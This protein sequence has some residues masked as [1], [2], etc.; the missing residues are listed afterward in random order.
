MQAVDGD[1][2]VAG[3]LD[4]LTAMVIVIGALGVYFTAAAVLVDI[5][6]DQGA[7]TAHAGL[8]AQERLADDVLKYD[9]GNETLAP[10][11]VRSFF[12][13]DANRTCGVADHGDGQAFLRGALGVGERFAVNATLEDDRGP[14]TMDPTGGGRPYRH[15]IGASVPDDR[16]VTV[17]ERTVTFGDDTDGDGRLDYFT[18]RLRLWEGSP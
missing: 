1:R 8:R 18:V 14:V 5:Q 13:G 4:F 17:Y 6:A 16:P 15:A 2:G 7:S 3:L 11:C 9:P 10:G 12:T